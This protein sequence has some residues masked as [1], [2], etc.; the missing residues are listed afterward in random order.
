MEPPSPINF[1]QG[2]FA[3]LNSEEPPLQVVPETFLIISDPDDKQP[4]RDL[5][6][7]GFSSRT[8]LSYIGRI[9]PYIS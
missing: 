8:G 2:S 1:E 4:E 7:Y 5:L 9:V 3:G 6:V